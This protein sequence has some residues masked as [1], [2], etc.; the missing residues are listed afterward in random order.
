MNNHLDNYIIIKNDKVYY[1]DYSNR[2]KKLFS[3]KFKEQNKE[4]RLG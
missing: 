4:M 1:N 3:Y 2:S